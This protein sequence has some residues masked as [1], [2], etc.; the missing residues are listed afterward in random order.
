MYNENW[1]IDA[2]SNIDE[3]YLEKYFD[4]K[5][6]I[7]IKKKGIKKIKR[8]VAI[9]TATCF[10]VLVISLPF[11]LKIMEPINMG[12]IGSYKISQSD[13]V[14]EGQYIEE[15]ESTSYLKKHENEILSIVSQR[16]NV[17]IDKLRISYK[18]IYHVNLTDKTNFINYDTIRF[19][20]VDD[21][22]NL[23]ASIDL[24]RENKSFNYQ[25]SYG[26]EPLNKLNEIL[27]KHVDTNFALVYIGD[28]VEAL[29]APDNTIYF[30]NGGKEIEEN[31]DYYTK[32]DKKIN[33][34]NYTMLE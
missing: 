6:N 12:Q 19:Y 26:G 9:A 7:Q 5:R 28:F 4:I 32:F 3:T 8:N 17:G 11:V 2:I 18:G 31:I 34:I 14:F 21:D 10:M 25:L 29:I 27:K 22:V 30:L 20:V 23:I 15:S 16:V 33:I 13:V 1:L 24:Y